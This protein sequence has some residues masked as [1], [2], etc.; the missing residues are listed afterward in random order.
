VR[1]W[2]LWLCGGGRGDGVWGDW[3]VRVHGDAVDGVSIVMQMTVEYVHAYTFI[4]CLH[5]HVAHG[6]ED[7]DVDVR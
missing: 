7:V 3:S 1:A 4:Y 5:P 2:G 6:C